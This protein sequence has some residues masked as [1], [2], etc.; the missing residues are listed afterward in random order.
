MNGINFGGLIFTHPVP[1]HYVLLPRDPGLYAVQVYNMSFGP[2]PYQPI[3]F[4]A[5]SKLKDERLAAHEAFARWQQHPLAGSG[6]FVSTIPLRYESEAYRTR[7]TAALVEQ[8]LQLDREQA[9]RVQQ[10]ATF[11]HDDADAPSGS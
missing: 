8:Y 10:R 7:T 6:L 1:L 5:S 3:H 4:G 11:L 9:K 2:L